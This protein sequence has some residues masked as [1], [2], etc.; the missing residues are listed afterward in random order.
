[1]VLTGSNFVEAQIYFQAFSV[2]Y[3]L[4]LRNYLP[5][6]TLNERLNYRPFYRNLLNNSRIFLLRFHKGQSVLFINIQ[7]LLNGL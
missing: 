1:M 5:E 6:L 2:P 7:I 3:L 4:K